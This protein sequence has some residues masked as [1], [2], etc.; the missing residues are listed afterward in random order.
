MRGHTIALV[1]FFAATTWHVVTAKSAAASNPDTESLDLLPATTED[2]FSSYVADIESS[3]K[4]ALLSTTSEILTVLVL[5]ALIIILILGNFSS[6]RAPN[7]QPKFVRQQPIISAPPS[8]IMFD[9]SV[10]DDPDEFPSDSPH[11]AIENRQPPLGPRPSDFPSLPSQPIASSCPG[12][13]TSYSGSTG[14]STSNACSEKYFIKVENEF[15]EVTQEQA[16]MFASQGQRVFTQ[17]NRENAGQDIYE[18]LPQS[19]ALYSTVCKNPASKSQ[20]NDLYSLPVKIKSQSDTAAHQN[21]SNSPPAHRQMEQPNVSKFPQ[22]VGYSHGKQPPVEKNSSTYM[23]FHLDPSKSVTDK[24]IW[25]GQH[26]TKDQTLLLWLQKDRTRQ[27]AD[28]L[29]QGCV[30]PTLFLK[31]NK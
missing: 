10:Y 4:D 18:A 26:L 24:Q 2:D 7:T 17:A 15:K 30:P 28:G 16:M 9:S 14:V 20:P 19:H 11:A 3:T 1:L 29:L 5:L 6:R 13:Q 22:T 31:I 21:Q 25:R 8:N 23:N 27:D 12:N